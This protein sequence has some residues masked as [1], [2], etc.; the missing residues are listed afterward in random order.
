MNVALALLDFI[1]SL[2]A[3]FLAMPQTVIYCSYGLLLTYSI[4]AG[5][6]V[7][8]RAGIKPLWILLTIVPTINIIALWLWTYTRWP[9]L[10]RDK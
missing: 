4:A 5:G 10:P 9:S 6:F 7:L 8:A 3:W 1:G 2:S